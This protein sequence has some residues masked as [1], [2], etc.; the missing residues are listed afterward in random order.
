MADIRAVA[1]IAERG[2]PAWK[3][4]TGYHRRSLA[5]NAIYRFKQWFGDRLASRQLETQDNGRACADRRP[6]HDDRPGH[7]GYGFSRTMKSWIGIPGVLMPI[8]GVKEVSLEVSGQGRF[9]PPFP[10][11]DGDRDVAKGR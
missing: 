10:A 6:E 11:P 4:A 2:L 8:G 9:E 3:E 1:D 7:A 5:E